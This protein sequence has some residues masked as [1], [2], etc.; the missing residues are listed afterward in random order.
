MATTEDEEGEAE[1][2][3]E[4]CATVGV[5]VG[6]RWDWSMSILIGWCGIDKIDAPEKNKEMLNDCK[7]ITIS[8]KF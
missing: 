7:I 2:L 4:V 6:E 1:L 5:V 8:S 3:F